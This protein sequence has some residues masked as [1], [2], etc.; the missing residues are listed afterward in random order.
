MNCTIG[1]KLET[2]PKSL[3]ELNK[4]NEAKHLFRRTRFDLSVANAQAICIDNVETNIFIPN[5]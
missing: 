4:Y 2:P 5:N 1:Y 3:W